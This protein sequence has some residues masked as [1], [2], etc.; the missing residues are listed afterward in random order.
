MNSCRVLVATRKQSS[1]F[2]NLLIT[3]EE[4]GCP[5]SMNREGHS[6]TRKTYFKKETV[7]GKGRKQWKGRED[8]L[9]Q[10]TNA[11]TLLPTSLDD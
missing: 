7:E 5:W 2:S 10:G 8:S 11:S 1:N 4:Q 3:D 6:L 9:K